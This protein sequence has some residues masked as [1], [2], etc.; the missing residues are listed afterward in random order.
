MSAPSAVEPRTGPARARRRWPRRVVL[1]VVAL[2]V[3]L[4]AAW[5]ATG[6]YFSD[7]AIKPDHPAAGPS[8]VVYGTGD[9][10][11]TVIM[12]ATPNTLQPGRHGLSW[13]G[14]AAMVGGI[15]AR[16]H[17]HVERALLR[18]PAPLPGVR[19]G[20]DWNYPADPRSLIGAPIRT[21]GVRTELGT[22]PAW[23]LPAPRGSTAAH[24][25][26]WVIAVHGQNGSPQTELPAALPLH[27]LGLPVLAITY[28]NDAGAPAS[29]D[30]LY[31][32]G[33][34]EWR[35][36]DAAITTARRMGA[37]HVILAGGSMGGAMIFQT[38]AH[39]AQARIVSGVIDDA[40]EIDWARLCDFQS[41]EYHAPPG[42][43]R[44][45]GTIIEWR[46]GIDLNAMNVLKHPPAYRPPLLVFHGTADEENPVGESRD[47]AAAAKRLH[48]PIRYE[49]FRGAGHTQA[50]N[51]DPARYE[52]AVTAFGER[53][54]TR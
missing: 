29:P 31:H 53:V 16:P 28:R 37:R 43:G 20:L 40:G 6:W 46:T 49:E 27:R 14:G 35:D 32:L 19:V 38:L 9:G 21:V 17:G 52:A 42:S 23:Y 10:G 25:S 41:G 51:V 18:G 7:I 4:A 26:T 50:W 47:L 36:V 2:I 45:V 1:L 12:D 30:G 44:L 5:S 54:V 8:A 22:A 3:V 34:S 39:S 11:R 33:A 15:V 24:R 48:W 13:N